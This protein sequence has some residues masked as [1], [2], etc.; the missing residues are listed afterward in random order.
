MGQLDVVELTKKIIT[1][2]TMAGDGENECA[3]YLGHLLENNGFKVSYFD[4]ANNRTNLIAKFQSGSNGKPFVFTGHMDIVPLGEKPWQHDP[5]AGETDGDKL[6]GRGSTDM[7]GGVAAFVIAAIEFCKKNPKHNVTLLITAGEETG[8]EGAKYL[9][10]QPGVIEQSDMVIVGEPTKNK[11]LLGHRGVLWVDMVAHGV[12]AHGSMPE[13]GVNAIY[14]LATVIEKLKN[15]N[16]PDE[17]PNEMGKATLNVSEIEGGL[18]INSVPDYAKICVDFRTITGET[19]DHLVKTIQQL[20]GDD[21]TIHRIVDLGPVNTDRHHPLVDSIFSICKNILE[22][23]IAS[24]Y[25]P[26]FTDGSVFQDYFVDTPMLILGPGT[27]EMA[28]KTDEYILQSN[29]Q[30]GVEIY[31]QALNEWAKQNQ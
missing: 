13:E 20:I 3:K 12:T 8:C 30:K 5:F 24:S 22:Q 27:T 6:F 17:P 21:I 14:K 31:I 16:F 9:V 11:P 26:F 7:K 19:H 29:L 10:Q 28:H 18:N 23:D 25:A 2:K 4:F 1:I 15:F